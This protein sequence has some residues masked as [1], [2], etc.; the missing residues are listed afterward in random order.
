MRRSTKLLLGGF[1][2]F[3]GSCTV[4]SLATGS[5]QIGLHAGVWISLAFVMWLEWRLAK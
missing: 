3:A 5:P 2:F 1:G 4:I